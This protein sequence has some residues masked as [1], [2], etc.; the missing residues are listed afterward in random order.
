M[1]TV[2]VGSCIVV[3][4]AGPSS[5]P[6]SVVAL[7]ELGVGLLLS[8]QVELPHPKVGSYLVL[9]LIRI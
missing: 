2:V 8:V 7:T 6:F 5:G 4:F 1:K 3:V 9:R